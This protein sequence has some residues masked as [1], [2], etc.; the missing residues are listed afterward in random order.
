MFVYSGDTGYSEEFA[1]FA[2]GANL[3]VLECAVPDDT[4]Y[5]KHTSPSQ[6]G[7][8]AAFTGAQ[9]TILT[10]FYPVMEQEDIITKV[11][12]YYEGEILLANDG[13]TY[14]IS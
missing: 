4:P 1:T 6:A 13:M 8:M 12:K 11:R 9:T 3:L 5:D 7:K 14:E 2:Q 10:H